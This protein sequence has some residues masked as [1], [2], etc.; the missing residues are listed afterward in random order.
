MSEVTRRAALRTAAWGVPVIAVAAATPL[1]AASTPE[2]TPTPASEIRFIG[3]A[4]T[5]K[6][7][8]VKIQNIGS[9]TAFN[10]K[11]FI[12][13]ELYMQ[14]PELVGHQPTEQ[15]RIPRTGRITLVAWGDGT[16][17]ITEEIP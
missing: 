15:I 14:W 3:L 5:P 13:D 17:T 1:A 2:P 10:V 7:V 4:V 11:L 6:E 8:K 12:N 9:G 16:N